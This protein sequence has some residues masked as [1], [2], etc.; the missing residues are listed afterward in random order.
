MWRRGLLIS[1]LTDAAF[2]RDRQGAVVQ[3]RILHDFTIDNSE[4]R[5]WLHSMQGGKAGR[6]G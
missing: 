3:G 4:A 6:E 1:E 5:Q 2:T